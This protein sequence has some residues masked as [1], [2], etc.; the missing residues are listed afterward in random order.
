MQ[1]TV[2]FIKKFPIKETLSL[3]LGGLA[4]ISVFYIGNTA[5]KAAVSIPEKPAISGT[6]D[7]PAIEITPSLSSNEKEVE[8]LSDS[9]YVDGKY[10]ASAAGYNGDITVE[11]T[12]KDGKMEEINIVDCIDDE[13]YVQEAMKLIKKMI[14]AQSADVDAVSGATYSSNGIINATADCLAQATSVGN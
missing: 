8:Q 10:I 14:K 2:D 6:E 3:L 4:V 7:S 12:I 9:L 5:R 13:L 1:R 11:V